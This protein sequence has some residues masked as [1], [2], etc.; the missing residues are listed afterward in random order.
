MLSQLCRRISDEVDKQQAHPEKPEEPD[1]GA[2]LDDGTV[3]R[4]LRCS[5]SVPPQP[6]PGKRV[7]YQSFKS[8]SERAYALHARCI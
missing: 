4:G 8:M 1:L 2:C 5:G 6:D 3:R 7:V